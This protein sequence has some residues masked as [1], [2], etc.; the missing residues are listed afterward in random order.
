MT[1]SER[2]SPKI[3]GYISEAA[4]SARSGISVWTLRRWRAIGYGP[5]WHKFGRHVLYREDASERFLAEQEAA[6]L[7]KE[8]RRG[9][10]R[11]RAEL[12]GN[13]RP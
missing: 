5:K 7:Q 11:M 10:P 13:R 2:S 8:P 3:D 9:R 6:G 1:E 12:Y 4:Q